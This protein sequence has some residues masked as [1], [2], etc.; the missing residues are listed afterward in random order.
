MLI[1]SKINE[2]KTN[3][4]NSV[5][6]RNTAVKPKTKNVNGKSITEDVLNRI[7][8]EVWGYYFSQGN[9]CLEEAH[10]GWL[11]KSASVWPDDIRKNIF[12]TGVLNLMADTRKVLA[13]MQDAVMR[14]D[15][16]VKSIKNNDQ[17]A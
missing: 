11:D 10:D 9:R 3:E 2:F 1:Q 5:K 4:K 17:V 14:I 8:D 15:R 7:H 12:N 6:Q 13:E 16:D